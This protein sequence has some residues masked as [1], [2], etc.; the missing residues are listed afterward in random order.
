MP[1]P[2][3]PRS[4]SQPPSEPSD[5]PSRARPAALLFDLDGTLIDSI[6]LI[7]EAVEFAFAGRPGKGPTR[8]E[9][10]A[11]IGTPLVTQLGAFATD[12][13]DLRRLTAVYREYQHRHHD[14]LTRCYTGVADVLGALR[15]R[16]HPMAIVT[17]KAD[18]IARRS[19]DH[20]GLLPLMDVLIGAD[21]C[22][23]HKPDPEPVRL[24]LERLDYRAHEAIFIG[25]SPF[26][27]ASGKAA[28]VRTVAVTWGAFTRAQLEP[29]GADH[30]IDSVGELSGVVGGGP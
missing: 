14:R 12:A 26:D 21:S 9:W 10:M 28:G 27:I 30:V 4:R 8:A 25:D 6:Q 11:G 13:E 5:G 29:L 3:A 17:S 2:S 20:V 18:A 15:E 19:L 22:A 23:R 1:P 24:A 7:V 16:G